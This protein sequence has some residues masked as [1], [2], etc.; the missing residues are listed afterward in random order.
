MCFAVVVLAGGMTTWELP[1]GYGRVK[2]DVMMV[3]KNIYG[4]CLIRLL[5]QLLIGFYCSSLHIM[6]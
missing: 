5:I 3:A 4:E 2:P 1:D 6:L